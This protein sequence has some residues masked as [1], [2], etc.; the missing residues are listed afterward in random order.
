MPFHD[1]RK[2]IIFFKNL[3]NRH[4]TTHPSVIV[5]LL[6]WQFNFTAWKHIFPFLFY[7]LLLISPFSLKPPPRACFTFFSRF[8]RCSAHHSY[9]SPNLYLPEDHPLPHFSFNSE[10][11]IFR[12]PFLRISV[13]FFKMY[14]GNLFLCSHERFFAVVIFFRFFFT[15]HSG[16]ARG[17]GIPSWDG[18]S[19]QF[20]PI[21][22]SFFF[23]FIF[24]PLLTSFLSRK[25][26]LKFFQEPSTKKSV[27]EERKR[28]SQ[29]GSWPDFALIGVS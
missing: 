15:R 18:G 3:T 6:I 1:F 23:I 21:F 10:I 22:L 27:P 4:W 11:I 12:F 26:E 24:S 16:I 7:F 25:H 2:V 17:T 19:V 29:E 28:C 14:F 9:H 8:S 13:P 20:S 5:P